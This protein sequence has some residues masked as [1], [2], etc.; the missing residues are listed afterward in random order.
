MPPS[1]LKAAEFVLKP[2]GFAPDLDPSALERKYATPPSRFVIAGGIRF[3]IRERG[4]GPTIVLIHG[5]SAHLYLWE[6][7]AELLAKDHHVISLDMPGHGLTGPDAQER[8]SFAGLANSVHALV[9][10]LGLDRFALAGNSLG[11]AVSTQYAITHPEKLTALFLLDG[12]GAPRDLVVPPAAFAAFLTPGIGDLATLFTPKWAVRAGLA[13]TYGDVSK[14]TAAE[15]TR[16]RFAAPSR[17]SYRPTQDLAPRAGDFRCCPRRTDRHADPAALGQSRHLGHRQIWRVVQ[18]HYCG[19]A[20][21]DLRWRRPPADGRSPR[22]DRRCDAEIPRRVERQP[23]CVN[24]FAIV[25]IP[26]VRSSAVGALLGSSR[27]C[28]VTPLISA[29]RRLPTA[30][31]VFG[32]RL[33]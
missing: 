17:Q 22:G 16:L 11:G 12:I 27:T 4:Q 25:F 10:A 8:Y 21:A 30:R 32:S 24:A 7:A 6:A 19:R 23:F 26:S 31:R 1:I 2:F 3:H 28:T 29:K 9:E 15:V 14:L 33:R 20:D 18:A 13:D 5:Q